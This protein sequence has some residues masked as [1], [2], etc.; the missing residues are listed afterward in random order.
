[1][2]ILAGE[3]AIQVAN[4][5]QNYFIQ[6]WES[7]AAAEPLRILRDRILNNQ[8]CRPQQ[9]LQLYQRLLRRR[10]AKAV[11]SLEEQELLHLGLIAKNG[12]TLRVASKI[13][14]FVF[15]PWWVS[16][17]LDLEVE[18]EPEPNSD[19]EPVLESTI[20]LGRDFSGEAQTDEILPAV[21]TP[22]KRHRTVLFWGL[23]MMA[24]GVSAVG[25]WLRQR[26]IQTSPIAL[27]SS[28]SFPKTSVSSAPSAPPQRQTH[29]AEQ[30]TGGSGP[31]LS[32]QASSFPTTGR[33]SKGTPLSAIKSNPSNALG[34][35]HSIPTGQPALVFFDSTLSV[36]I[37]L[38]GST[39]TQILAKLG[40]PTWNRQGYYPHSRALLYKGLVSKHV[41]FG[42]LLDSSTGRLRQTEMAFDQ[43][44]ELDAIQRVLKQLLGGTLPTSVQKP[45]REIYRRQRTS[46]SFSLKNW[47]GEIHRDRKGWIYLGVWDADFH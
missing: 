37:F 14:R 46:Y 32:T 24:I 47:E 7:S 36:P 28:P 34:N 11:G 44:I 23:F 40:P 2:F 43:S 30:P 15:N 10:E 39:Q 29:G 31:S 27:P 41:D 4:L 19:R 21:E 16:Q 1:M 6:N 9:L 35:K 22:A 8:H 33:S 20:K 45:L 13:Y 25:V 18:R 38:T 17:V 12:R 5:V 42:Y 3:E 26:S